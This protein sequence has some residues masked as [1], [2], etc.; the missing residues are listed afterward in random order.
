[1]FLGIYFPNGKRSAERLRYKM[2][3]YD[4]FLDYVDNL[5]QQGRNVVVCAT[6]TPH[7]RRSTWR[8]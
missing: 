5:R 7:T 8:A 1:M 3:F 2:E 4:A 6:S